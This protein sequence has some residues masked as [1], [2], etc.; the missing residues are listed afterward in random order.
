MKKLFGVICVAVLVIS[1]AGTFGYRP[2]F[3]VDRAG[4]TV[5]IT[6]PAEQCVLYKVL[7]A[8]TTYYRVGLFTANY[9]ALKAKFYTPEEALKQLDIIQAA[10]ENKAATV[11]SIVNTLLNVAASASKVGAPEIILVT[12]GLGVYAGDMT[13]IDDCTWYKLIAYIGKQRTL[14]MAFAAQE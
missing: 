12:E 7:G 11:G 13:P 14:I 4:Q 1:C 3:Y 5:E 10:V 6:A 9:A 2:D 8:N